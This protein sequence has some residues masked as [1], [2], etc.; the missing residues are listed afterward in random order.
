MIRIRLS[1]VPFQILGPTFDITVEAE[2]DESASHSADVDFP[3][4]NPTELNLRVAVCL[5]RI[6]TNPIGDHDPTGTANS[7]PAYVS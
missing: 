6:C 1:I 5:F 4:W 3:S 7:K 2:P